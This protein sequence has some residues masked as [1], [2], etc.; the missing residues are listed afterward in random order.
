MNIRV[1]CQKHQSQLKC[2]LQHNET[3]LI[4]LAIIHVHILDGLIFNINGCHQGR[5]GNR[6]DNK[7]YN[8]VSLYY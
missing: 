7:F 2:F 1:I 6:H 4:N 3:S 8:R 5:S